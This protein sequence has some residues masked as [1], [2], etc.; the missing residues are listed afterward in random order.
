M[1]V[2]L[3]GNGLKA[4]RTRFTSRRAGVWSLLAAD[5]VWS[6]YPSSISRLKSQELQGSPPPERGHVGMVQA[7]GRAPVKTQKNKDLFFTGI[8]HY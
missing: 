7:E 3:Q 2:K 6:P 8:F 5:Q 4:Y 1:C